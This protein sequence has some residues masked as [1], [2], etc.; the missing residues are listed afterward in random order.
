MGISCTRKAFGRESTAQNIF[1][2]RE[3]ERQYVIKEKSSEV[4]DG[5]FL[6]LRPN[7]LASEP[8]NIPAG[9]TNVKHP[10]RFLTAAVGDGIS[11]DT[12]SIQAIVNH[13]ASSKNNKVFFPRGEYLVSS[14]IAIP[15]P[16]ELHGT[17]S[18]I[19]VIKSSTPYVFQ[20][21]NASPVKSVSLNNVYFDGIRV[22]FDG[23][24]NR[25]VPGPTAMSNVTINSC[26]FF[27]S[28]RPTPRNAEREQLEM[29]DLRNSNVYRNIFL[30][31][32]NA[33]G[34][35]SK[36][37]FTVGVEV[38]ENICGL[39]LGKIGWLATKVEPAW[40]WRDQK[41]KLEF[42]M[43][44]YN[45]ESDQGFFQSC[46]YEACDER[47]RIVKNIFNGS[48]NT[49]RFRDHVMYLKGFNM[50]EVVSNYVRGWPADYSGGIKARNGK[51][52]LVARNYLDD[53]GIFLYT[54][55]TI[56]PCLFNGL[57]NVVIYR[58]HIV[59]RT[60]PGHL[61]S[62]IYYYEPH[63]IGIDWNITYSANVFEIVGVS[64]PTN[65]ICIWL[66]N[67]DLS[68]HHVLQDNVYYGT[69]MP[70]K[71]YADDSTPLH[72]T[73]KNNDSITNW[74]NYPL[75]KLNIPPY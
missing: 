56:N 71:L 66:T 21:Y 7:Y 58:N 52:L 46:C 34:V 40:Y 26:V 55:R 57:K 25:E 18:G 61:T 38:R 27:S 35:A 2:R 73:E 10:G 23:G 4:D 41:Q 63:D 50:M 6:L 1:L 75:Y 60:N 59:Q 22:N 20:V 62:G 45:L 67:G 8:E 16:V 5:E 72:E 43:T 69:K 37:I 74:Y 12:S 11:D 31:D 13:A 33:Y 17:Q 49:G 53:T 54:H 32:S 14:N 42:L 29:M 64:D 51:N 48:P 44:H 15:G 39:D 36:F 24:V 47:M 28:G 19:A 3:G 65:Y 68:Q 9:M 30:R 70:V